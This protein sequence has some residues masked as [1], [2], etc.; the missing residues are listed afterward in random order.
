M[1]FI[2][3]YFLFLLIIPFVL[4][5]YMFFRVPKKFRYQVNKL[6]SLGLFCICSILVVF[7]VSGF[8]FK[9][10]KT[11]KV[12][13]LIILVDE[14]ES[15]SS[16]NEVK[17]NFVSK[18]ID[19][20]KDKFKVSI[21][22]FAKEPEL[23]CPF[24]RDR[25]VLKKSL[26]NK[27]PIDRTATNIEDALKFSLNTFTQKSGGKIVLISDLC[28]TEKDLRSVLPLLKSK[29]ILLDI[30]SLKNN[31]LQD[32]VWIKSLK[33]PGNIKLNRPTRFNLI[34]ESNGIEDNA[35]LQGFDNSN[36]FIKRTIKVEKGEN[37]IEFEHKFMD[38]GFHKLSFEIFNPK[39]KEKNNNTFI[40]YVDISQV[41]GVLILETEKI[42]GIREGEIIE[43]ILKKKFE[44]VNRLNI[45]E[46]PNLDDLMSYNQIILANV[47]NKDLP[48]GYDEVLRTYVEQIGG[49]ILTIGGNKIENGETKNNA[50]NEEDLKGSIYQTLLPVTAEEY[51]PP[52]AVC[53]LIDTSGSMKNKA[54]N[55]QIKVDL[56]REAAIKSLESLND[57]DYI[58]VIKF[59][60]DAGVVLPL[61]PV[62]HR[63][64]IERAINEYINKTTA[65]GGT[66]YV[67]ALEEAGII[68]KSAKE[69][70]KK[71]I[72][73]ISDGRPQNLAS[74]Y[75]QKV[76]ENRE[77][78]ITI[79]TIAFTERIKELERIAEIG[80]GKHYES[81]G[82]D[83]TT[84]IHKDLEQPTIRAF[85]QEPFVMKK[86]NNSD[87]FMGIGELDT[88]PKLLGFYG[89]RL[90]KDAKAY[91]VGQY[92]QPIYANWQ[93]EKGQV[94]SLLIDLNGGF[95]K[96]L[97]KN[98]DGQQLI[99]NIVDDLMPKESILV[100]DIYLDIMQ[101]NY[102]IK[103]SVNSKTSE[104]S[105]L[106]IS[107]EKSEVTGFNQVKKIKV[108][109]YKQNHVE[110]FVLPET[111]LYKITVE[112]IFNNK[113][114]SAKT[115]SYI[116]LP[117]SAEF[118]YRTYGKKKVN[119][120]IEELENNNTFNIKM[121]S[122]ASE[123]YKTMFTQ[124]KISY[125]PS[126][127]LLSITI[128]LFCVDMVIRKFRLGNIKK[129]RGNE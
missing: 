63:I 49:S 125:D 112:Q 128:C 106:F 95:S 55:G 116:A 119:K 96:D 21:V 91:I 71:H 60:S 40:S 4:S 62:S 111:G 35:I 36:Q 28:E 24:T 57:R 29:N 122:S 113:K 39:D 48:K 7:V 42:P 61:T 99:L 79:S 127:V 93:V 46:A 126:I 123:V 31:E 17:K 87:I 30:Y 107:I 9:Y 104:N 75:E 97:I 11:D 120:K 73:L 64:V 16:Q 89:T 58:S 23:V 105:E 92:G 51:K 18:I 108:S 86:L 69:I 109:S 121:I 117:Y 54:T 20:N 103:I 34:I 76:K 13:E 53:L 43:N 59:S 67:E 3:P 85:S 37:K 68:L 32:D 80:G 45:K 129:K 27:K 98:K 83:L 38:L 25:E 78:G 15:I 74:E 72:I 102:Q 94:G 101:D 81:M 50:Y 70:N 115:Y 56:A 8:N 77:A 65:G 52:V 114:A 118:D 44:N 10:E 1:N 2:R 19:G 100:P 5:I 66:S 88:L 12:K 41:D 47:S 14:S 33:Q 22:R 110:N 6:I 124:R 26:D 84:K 82:S 90:K